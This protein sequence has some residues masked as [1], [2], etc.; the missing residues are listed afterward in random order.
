MSNEKVVT[1]ELVH[2]SP[3]GGTLVVKDALGRSHSA[4]FID[5]RYWAKGAEY[6]AYAA[7]LRIKRFVGRQVIAHV[8][9]H[10]AFGDTVFG[11]RKIKIKGKRR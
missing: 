10:S 5:P 4:R 3:T 2:V 11:G 7:L 6:R 1:G 8:E 9:H